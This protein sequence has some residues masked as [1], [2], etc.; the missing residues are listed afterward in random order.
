MLPSFAFSM[1][2]TLFNEMMVNLESGK[3]T[4]VQ[5]FLDK[6]HYKFS[7]D[8]EFYVIFLNY[9]FKKGYK[10]GIVIAKGKG[11]KGDFEIRNKD[12]GEQVGFIGNRTFDNSEIILYSISETRKAIKYFNNRLDIH[13]GIVHIAAKIKKWDIL[14]SQL[15]DILSVSKAIKNDWVWGSIN[16]MEGNPK[17]F[18][19]E[20]VQSKLN[21]L[22][23]IGNEEADRALIAVS[24]K[25]IE[26]YPEII[27]GYSNLGILY[28]TNKKYALAEKYLTQAERINPEDKIV[29]VN[30]KKLRQLKE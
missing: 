20:N 8:P 30:I 14:S 3:D 10:N 19:I 6:N 13:L 24:K 2:T 25:M 16:S 12:T 11:Q 15:I 21:E 22:F 7:K 26:E 27:Y 18:M 9:S 28:L 23:Y 29:K 1:D 17:Q 4:I 5:N